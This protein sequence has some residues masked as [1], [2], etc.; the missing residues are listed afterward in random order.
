MRLDASVVGD[1]KRPAAPTH[2]SAGGLPP[3][4]LFAETEA[5]SGLLTG[6]SASLSFCGCATLASPTAG[7]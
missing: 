4:A 1:G 7:G 2:N 3:S 6:F 5:V